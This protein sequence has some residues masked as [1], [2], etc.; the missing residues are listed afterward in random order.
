[1]L[2]ELE[3]ILGALTP[4]FALVII[5]YIM[6]RIRFPDP[7][8][9][10]QAERLTYYFLFPTLLVYKIGSANLPS[11]T[12][13]NVILC[14][15]ALLLTSAMLVLASG[16]FIEKDRAKLTSI[17][18]GGIR[19]NTYVGLAAASALFGDEGLVWGAVFMA[20]MIPGINL[21]CISCF[22]V[23]IPE[24]KHSLLKNLWLG[25]SRNP[26][27]LACLFGA[28]LNITGVGIPKKISPLL[29]LVS[30]MALPLGLLA[31]GVGLKL[32][33]FKQNSLSLWYATFFKLIVYPLLFLLLA[34]WFDLS[35]TVTMV[36]LLFAVLPTAPSGYIL[37]RQLKGDAGLMANI[38]TIQTLAAM[39]TM[40]LMIALFF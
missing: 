26:L 39:L 25:V 32:R 12:I 10:P 27:I 40:P 23:L 19:F 22:A 15:V 28:L 31:V 5:G 6:N 16:Y 8:F 38:I 24:K 35:E 30:G 20:I 9:W 11:A 3:S 21:A 17:F 14:L 29:Q 36:I 4:V 13:T 37:A 2:T 34:H 33:E 7:A 1:M 18:Q